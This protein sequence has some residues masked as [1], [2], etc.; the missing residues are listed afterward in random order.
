MILPRL[1]PHT[2]WR[3]RQLE[4]LLLQ[5]AACILRGRNV[6]RSGVISRHDNNDT[7][8]MA[9]RLDAIA[10]RIKSQYREHYEP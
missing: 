1:I 10:R 4:T 9:E 2:G 3:R 7:Y 8:G 6:S 5:L